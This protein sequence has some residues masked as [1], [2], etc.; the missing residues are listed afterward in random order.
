VSSEYERLRLRQ[1]IAENDIPKL[2]GQIEAI[3]QSRKD[4]FVAGD[5]ITIADL[6]SASSCFPFPE[7]V[8]KCARECV[9]VS[10]KIR[11]VYGNRCEQSHDST[12]M[13]LPSF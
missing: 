8:W 6:V 1:Q 3:L 4:T 2:F 10:K 12:N 9:G 5:Q 11:I 7:A 13:R